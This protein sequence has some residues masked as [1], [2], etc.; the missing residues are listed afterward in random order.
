MRWFTPEGWRFETSLGKN[1]QDPI[2]SQ[3]TLGVVVHTSQEAQA[4]GL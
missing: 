3:N 1:L 2:S 4:G